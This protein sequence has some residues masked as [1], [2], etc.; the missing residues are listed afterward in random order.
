MSNPSDRGRQEQRGSGLDARDSRFLERVRDVYQRPEAAPGASAA[1]DA[2]LEAR[3]SRRTTPIP[4]WAG[5]AAATAAVASV[6]AWVTLG[7]GSIQ[8]VSET[9]PALAQ[10]TATFTPEEALLAL[11][12]D[13]STSDVLPDDYL[14]IEGLWLSGEQEDW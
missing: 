5:L 12:M 11:A 2:A 9:T 1:F 8:P 7:G 10:A 4:L 3:L 6:A 14:A 13:E